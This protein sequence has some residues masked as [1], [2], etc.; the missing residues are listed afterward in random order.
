MGYAWWAAIDVPRA[1]WRASGFPLQRTFLYSAAVKNKKKED[2]MFG[3]VERVILPTLVLFLLIG[4]LGGAALGAALIWRSDVALRFV[5]RMN[6]WVSTRQALRA[7]ETPRMLEA[8]S[9]G[10][11]RWLG[12]F[13]LFGGALGV[14]LLLAR[15]HVER[16]GFV[17]GVDLRRWFLSGVALATTKWLLVAGAA[18][19]FAI[20]L[21]MLFFPERL[22]ALEIRMNRW[23]SPRRLLAAEE[24]MH[25]PLEPR[26]AAHPRAAGWIIGAASL[27]VALGMFAL[28]LVK[29]R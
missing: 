19:A 18:F 12:A 8:P 1:R 2:A 24:T 29:L 7:L 9:P 17:P 14:A 5:A 25:M 15:L 13:L 28:L 27:A 3:F 10:L 26:V 16:A 23:Y 11:R 20:G 6:R 4:G 22:A 21:L